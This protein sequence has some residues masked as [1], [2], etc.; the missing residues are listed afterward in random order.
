MIVD[1]FAYIMRSSNSRN[2]F[3]KFMV[4]PSDDPGPYGPKAMVAVGSYYRRATSTV[5][6]GAHALSSI[7]RSYYHPDYMPEL[8]PEDYPYVARHREWKEAEELRS[9]AREQWPTWDEEPRV[10]W[11]TWETVLAELR[12]NPDEEAND[13]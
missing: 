6:P 11:P 12:G 7:A 1:S 2:S 13:G 10:R 3:Y 4:M 8:P 5:V 9:I